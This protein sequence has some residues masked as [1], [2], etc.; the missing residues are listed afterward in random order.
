MTVGGIPESLR[1]K[2]PSYS[3][4]RELHP[5]RL[6]IV[7]VMDLRIIFLSKSPGW[8]GR[9]YLGSVSVLGG[10][11]G[12]GWRG[13]G[14]GGGEVRG[15]SLREHYRRPPLLSRSGRTAGQSVS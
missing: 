8:S 12:S 7:P 3:R 4:N 13:V 11:G 6:V 5:R 2:F 10:G 1:C 15:L 9:L 14:M